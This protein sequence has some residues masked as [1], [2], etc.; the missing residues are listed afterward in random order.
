MAADPVG[1]VGPLATL[2]IATRSLAPLKLFFGDGCGLRCAGPL[3][4]SDLAR[5]ARERLWSLGAGTRYDEYSFTRSEIAGAARLRILRMDCSGEPWRQGWQPQI[6][7]PYTIGFPSSDQDAFDGRLR[8][9]GFGARNPVERARFTHEDGRSWEVLESLATAPEF[10]A[11]VGIARGS[12]QPPISQVDSQGVGG[13]AYSM[14][15]VPDADAMATFL[16]RVLGYQ[17]R[18]RRRQTSSGLA[19]AMRTPDGTQ[20]EIAQ[21]AP[22]GAEHGFLILLQ[23]VNLAVEKPVAAPRLPASGLVMYS[24]PVDALEPV[25]ERAAAAGAADLRGPVHVDD[26]GHGNTRHG[27]FIA[28]NGVMFELFESPQSFSRS[29]TV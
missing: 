20:F 14:M 23:F 17:L 22:P 26:P 12:G 29:S 27:S 10:V 11:A 8:S 18:N 28:P 7:G 6:L 16:Q 15:V 21:L 25:L 4:A 19:G 24:F 9:L 5:L 3:P 13:P 2:T 1:R